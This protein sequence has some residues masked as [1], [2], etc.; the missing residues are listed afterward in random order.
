VDYCL[1]SSLIRVPRRGFSSIHLCCMLFVLTTLFVPSIAAQ[2]VLAPYI[3]TFAGNGSQGL[4]NGAGTSAE[5]YFPS[6]LAS[7][8]AGNIY[9]Y[10][11]NNNVVRKITSA[12]VVSTFA[13]TGTAGFSGDFGPATS[14]KI[15]GNGQIATDP[16]GNV[17]ISD[18]QRIRVINTA[19][20]I[21]TLL[22][23]FTNGA[24]LALASDS[25][26]NLYYV[27]PTT[28][29][30][31]IYQYSTAGV[32]SV[33]AGNGSYPSTCDYTGVATSSPIYAEEITVDSSGNLYFVG[34]CYQIFKISGGNI[35]LYAGK[36][37][38]G[39][40]GDGG[41]AIDAEFSQIKQITTDAFGDLYVND[42]YPN[43]RVRVVY[44]NGFINT[45]AGTGLDPYLNS[46]NGDGI[47][48]IDA[49]LSE[50]DGVTTDSS[51][52]VYIGDEGSHRVREVSSPSNITFP[53]TDV[54]QSSP[55][56]TVHLE[57]TATETITSITAP[58]SPNGSPD[59]VI[60]TI[61]G[62]SIGN[63]GSNS[64]GTI[65][66]VPITF[67]PQFAGLRTAPLQIVTST[68]NVNIPMSGVGIAPKLGFTPG[69]ITTVAG[70]GTSLSDCSGAATNCALGYT[71]GV[72][73]DVIGNIYISGIGE[74]ADFISKVSVSTGIVS[75][76]AGTGTEGF[77]GDA[78]P[79]VSAELDSP[80]GVAVDTSGNVYF[81]DARNN[82]IRVVYYGGTVA[83][84]SGLVVGNI[85]T[86][87]GGGSSP[88][89]CAGSSDS[90]GDGC[91]ATN[92][93]LYFPYGVTL[94]S[95]GNLYIADFGNARIRKVTTAG[96]ISTYAG[97]GTS[98]TDGRQATA[99]F[100]N[101]PVGVTV[102]SVGNVYFS[103]TNFEGTDSYYVRKVTPAG[104]ISTVAG[105]NSIVESGDGSLA[106][107]A[108]IVPE[109][110]AMDSANNLYIADPNLET[111][112]TNDNNSRV[113]E[114][115]SN[116]GYISTVAGD[117]TVGYTGDNGAAISAE[118]NS[119]LGVA[120]DSTGNF[121]IADTFNEVIRLV[122]VNKS[123]F[124]YG[125]ATPIG[126]MDSVDGPQAVTV[127]NNGNAPMIFSSPSSGTNPSVGADF[128]IDGATTCPVLNPGDPTYTLASGASCTYAVDFIP[129][130]GGQLT[131]SLV[132]TTNDPNTPNATVTLSGTGLASNCH[133]R[134]HG[135]II[136]TE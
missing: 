98:Y 30:I 32:T 36:G 124:S 109:G 23:P 72:A 118:L 55:V 84:L 133:A 104:I 135:G 105:N 34:G 10:D 56:Q 108:G 128:A 102:D 35:S 130:T 89:T 59:F 27:E 4:V 40:S 54:G 46:Y 131:E 48:A 63:G 88:S 119:P 60:G 125:T 21:S 96:V 68:G 78:G 20:T 13:G 3:S 115:S 90:I 47:L 79:A 116:N 24:P 113:R 74:N 82:R 106:T 91:L 42:Y 129:T 92:A 85:Y 120:V 122:A 101:S 94:D 93:E 103:V 39:F 52:N 57:V 43:D 71:E 123:A 100:L 37:T 45:F 70:G 110:L 65:C 58:N 33:F 73:I 18:N 16:A 26:G 7:D 67:I 111:Y 121:Y 38:S 22:G 61:T 81:A 126:A 17:Y 28:A 66:T 44:P 127:S 2:V 134:P 53:P 83:G 15:N 9:V 50:A 49:D 114:V 64:A 97:G 107:S 77:S 1:L 51:G 95:G 25:L 19:G 62:C 117:G 5:F 99:S 11:L 12:G 136:C 69:I 76:I 87:A 29:A 6:Q 75:H 80:Y 132:L 31:Q 8:S 41:Q 86:V 14:A 112:D